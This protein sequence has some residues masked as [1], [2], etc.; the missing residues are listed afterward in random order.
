M[1]VLVQDKTLSEMAL[2]SLKDL[3]E[4]RLR[5]IKI[6]TARCL[7][8]VK[9][10]ITDYRMIICHPHVFGSCWMPYIL[11]ANE[12]GVP[13]VFIYRVRT[14]ETEVLEAMSD[15]LKIDL[16]RKS[17]GDHNFYFD[18]IRDLESRL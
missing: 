5:N 17:L 7:S 12:R 16:R 18:L 1:K 3:I 14:D 13:I 11:K 10:N 9:S 15:N 8:D 2:D 6:D 4:W